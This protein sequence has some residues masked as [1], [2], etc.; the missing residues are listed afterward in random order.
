[1]SVNLVGEPSKGIK[2]N[3]YN[4][5]KLNR[6]ANS[7]PLKDL[8]T[9]DGRKADLGSD[10][11]SLFSAIASGVAAAVAIYAAYYVGK[12]IELFADPKSLGIKKLLG[13]TTLT[14][15]DLNSTFVCLPS[16]NSYFD[17]YLP[18]AQV[19]TKV[20][21]KTTCSYKGEYGKYIVVSVPLPISFGGGT[22]I[23]S[24]YVQVSTLSWTSIA[25]NSQN[26]KQYSVQAGTSAVFMITNELANSVWKI[27]KVST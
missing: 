21:N 13:N 7:S 18:L 10:F 26:Y 4:K 11:A 1:M 24:R 16:P 27:V 23:D 17:V 6:A 9:R 5:W 8:L 14:R 3:F 20:A 12:R 2:L 15:S 19:C 25:G 22:V